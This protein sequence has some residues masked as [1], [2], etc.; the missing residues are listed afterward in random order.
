[1]TRATPA[2]AVRQFGRCRVD[3]PA[4]RSPPAPPA[5]TSGPATRT[6]SPARWRASHAPAASGRSLAF[7]VLGGATGPRLAEY[8]LAASRLLWTQ[9][10][11]VTTRVGVGTDVLVHGSKGS[12]P[13]GQLVGRDIAT[14]AR[15]LAARL[16]VVGAPLR[17]RARRRRAASSSPG[18]PPRPASRSACWRAYDAAHGRPALAGEAPLGAGRGPAA[19]GGVVAVPL[20]SQYVL[21][22]DARDRPRSSGRCSRPRRRPPSC[23]RCPRACSTARAGVF[24][25][26]RDTARGSRHAAGL[27]GGAAAGVRAADLRL[28]SLPPRAE[29]VLGARS[30]PRPL[31]RDRR[32]RQARSSATGW[33]SC[34]TTASSSP[35]TPPRPRSG[36]PTPAPTTRSPRPTPGAHPVR[37][38]RRRARRARSDHRRADL[39]ARSCRARWCAAPPSTP[40]GSRRSGAAASTPPDLLG[41]LTAI[42][43][44]PDQRFPASSCSPSRS[45]GASRGA[46]SPPS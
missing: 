8:D 39:P 26:G 15:A 6:T 10:T 30:Q 5:P 23:A 37:H 46:R 19:R 18:R 25:L 35:S 36:G 3:A 22:F 20:E 27:P 12:T 17:L 42:I 16:P 21:L 11:D 34:T 31:A 40:T 43:A 45:S 14:G 2:S 29:R 41:A 44:D 33:P 7:L 32:R 9:P 24:L 38:G 28:R 13:N 1:M 4:R